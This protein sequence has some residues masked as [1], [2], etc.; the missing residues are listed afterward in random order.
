MAEEAPV[1][2]A[3]AAEEAVTVKGRG[4]R[5]LKRF[6]SVCVGV[7][8]AAAVLLIA[9]VVVARLAPD[10]VDRILYTEEELLLIHS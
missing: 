9:Y 6:V 4:R 2:E 8:A 1:P 7:L 3:A 5:R 10:F